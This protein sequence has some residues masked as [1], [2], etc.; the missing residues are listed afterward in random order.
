MLDSE[1]AEFVYV[2]NILKEPSSEEES[3]SQ[4][5]STS[6]EESTSKE[7]EKTTVAGS[8]EK[9]TK[10]TTGSDDKE[11]PQTGDYDVLVWLFAI[12]LILGVVMVGVNRKLIF[13]K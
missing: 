12:A 3:S 4:E 10:A 11:T 13:E 9:T 8:T 7:E 6:E 1:V 2:V 5:E